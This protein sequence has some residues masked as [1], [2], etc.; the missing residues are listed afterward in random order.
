MDS[1]SKIVDLDAIL[2]VLGDVYKQPSLLGQE[3]KYKIIP[4]DFTKDFHRILF[5]TMQRL[6]ELG[7]PTITINDIE[8]FL[9]KREKDFAVYETNNGNEFLQ[10]VI[11]AAEP[12]NF[13]YYYNR[14]K[15]FSLLRA[16]NEMAGLDISFIYDSENIFD[17]RKRKQQDDDLDSCSIEKLMEKVELQVNKVVEKFSDSVYAERQQAGE[18]GRALF[19]R[20]KKTPDV[21]VPLYGNLVNTFTRGAR[22]KKFYLRSAPSGYGKAIPNYT[23]IP[24]PKGMRRVDQIKVGD[25]LFDRLGKPTKVL[26]VYP[27]PKPKEVYEVKFN[28]GRAAECC[29]EH[30]WQIT[31]KN[32]KTPTVVTTSELQEKLENGEA[33]YLPGNQAFEYESPRTDF[34]LHPYVMG[35]FIGDGYGDVFPCDEKCLKPIIEKFTG[36]SCNINENKKDNKSFSFWEEKYFK[37]YPQLYGLNYLNKYI[38]QE[39]LYSSIE[40]R[41]WLLKGILDASGWIR[42]E[43]VAKNDGTFDTKIFMVRIKCTG[44]EPL[45]RQIQFLGNSLGIRTTFMKLRGG[46]QPFAC[47]HFDTLEMMDDYFFVE[48][49]KDVIRESLK[50]CKKYNEVKIL[51]VIPTGRFTDMTCFKVDNEEHLFLMNDCIVTHN[52]RTMIADVCNIACGWIYDER[53][54]WIKNGFKRPTLYISTELDA[55]EVQTMMWAFLSNVK[56][57]HILNNTYE[58]DEEERVLRAIEILEEAPLYIEIVPDFTLKDIENIIKRNVREHDVE[59]VGYDYLHSSIS[60]L[61]EITKAAGG[62]KL[63][64]DNILFMLSAKLK[65]LANQ[66]NV[67]IISSTQLNNDWKLSEMPDMSLLRGSRAIA[68]RIDIGWHLLPVTKKDLESLKDILSVTGLAPPKL[69]YCF[70]KNRRGK[71]KNAILWCDSHLETCRVNPMFAT[72][73]D[74][75]LLDVKE[76]NIIEKEEE[77]GAF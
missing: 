29:S 46:K 31:K 60:I 47:L 50:Y 52:S 37:E 45:I 36:M 18:G 33:W 73:Y 63:R 68:D 51:E 74:Y 75:E 3:D 44:N 66:L 58:G 48:R 2:Q 25:Y 15:K 8:S 34:Y 11:E 62:V 77:E 64:E 38:P 35:L 65:D 9:R 12:D 20:L 1:K 27:Q 59:V 23:L 32:G 24:T 70:Y 14:M 7:A 39:Y 4:S 40:N 67:F 72:T 76:L 16:Y 26:N 41:R 17:V 49:K 54:G 22:L 57:E 53:L 56:E 19:E 42:Y 21:G 6:Y 61:G 71:Y 43:R 5:G 30:L 10:K 28:D 13:E 69:K 55:E